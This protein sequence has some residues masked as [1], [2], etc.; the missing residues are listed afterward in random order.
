LVWRRT[1]R[2][3]YSLPG[4]KKF[5]L[6]FLFPLLTD[7]DLLQDLFFQFSHIKSFDPT[8]SFNV[9]QGMSEKTQQLREQAVEIGEDIQRHSMA[10]RQSSS[11]SIQGLRYL[12]VPCQ[13]EVSSDVN[14][15]GQELKSLFVTFLFSSVFR[16]LLIDVTSIGRQWVAHLASDISNAALHVHGIAEG[17]GNKAEK[18]E[19]GRKA[20]TPVKCTHPRKIAED[21]MSTA[22]DIARGVQE[23]INEEKKDWNDQLAETKGEVKQRLLTRMQEAGLTGFR[24]TIQVHDA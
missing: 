8:I 15:L 1:V 21:G 16:L 22:S 24:V 18:D 4:I 5:N 13:S 20:G 3:Y 19:F 23:S 10:F 6:F 14:T 12:L 17:V 9:A 2:V 7:D 11:K